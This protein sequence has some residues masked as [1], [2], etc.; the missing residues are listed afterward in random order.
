MHCNTNKEAISI[1][2]EKLNKQDAVLLKASN[3]LNF[4]EICEAIC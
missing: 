3:S 2:K 4:T 1:L